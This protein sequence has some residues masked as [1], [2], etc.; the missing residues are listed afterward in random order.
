MRSPS[1]VKLRGGGGCCFIVSLYIHMF[2]PYTTVCLAQE[3]QVSIAVVSWLDFL[4]N[5]NFDKQLK[6]TRS[7]PSVPH[8]SSLYAPD[9]ALIPV[10]PSG[11]LTQ[12]WKITISTGKTDY[13]KWQ[14]SIVNCKRHYQRLPQNGHSYQEIFWLAERHGQGTASS[15]STSSCPVS[16]NQVPIQR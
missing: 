15:G 12:L 7:F 11:E 16:N 1:S 9:F 4:L 6:T 3:K 2:Y 5:T 13:F 14:F 10:I 8:Q